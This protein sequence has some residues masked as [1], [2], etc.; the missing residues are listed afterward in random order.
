MY[1]NGYLY[2]Q[3][4]SGDYKQHEANMQVDRY[5]HYHNNGFSSQSVHFEYSQVVPYLHS[6]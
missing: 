3:G 2:S 1:I 6:G 4:E 5:T